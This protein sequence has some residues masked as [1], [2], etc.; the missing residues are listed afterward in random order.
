MKLWSI[1]HDMAPVFGCPIHD[2][3]IVMGGMETAC[4][5][6][7]HLPLPF[8][9]YDARSYFSERPRPESSSVRNDRPRRLSSLVERRKSCQSEGGFFSF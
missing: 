9:K 8:S 6:C 3:F 2:G 7:A 1:H 4:A 5:G